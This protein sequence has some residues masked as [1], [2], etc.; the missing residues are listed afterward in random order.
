MPAV[1]P[2]SSRRETVARRAPPAGVL[3]I[4]AG[5]SLWGV[6]GVLRKPLTG[7]WSSWTIVLYEH[8]ILTV[9]VAPILWIHRDRVR[10]LS[11]AGWLSA[12]VIGWGGSAIATLLF[13]EAFA[14]AYANAD[15]VIL[16][17]K[18]QPLWAIGA[19]ALVVGERP[20]GELGVLLVPAAIGTYLLSFGWASPADAISGGELR[21]ALYALGAAAL[22][23]SATAFGRRGLRE[24][25]PHVLM[26]LRFALAL[27]FLAVIAAP[28]HALLPAH[29]ATAG[30]WLRLPLLAL[31]SGLI[32]ML[33]YYR[34][35]RSTPAP[36]ATIA[37]LAFPATALVVNYIWLDATINGM[38][39]AGFALLWATIALIHRVPV[40]VPRAAELVSPPPLTSGA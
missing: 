11:R 2:V 18:T 6:D 39:W 19:A 31:G 15:V 5:A 10:R 26:A 8:L 32:A 17:Q 7:E 37:E 28:K 22:W 29:A 14:I 27:P 24:L 3:M 36:I 1:D 40:A 34:G 21:P 30:D 33:L 12:I 9:A 35:L 23:G 16:L 13:T 20:R 4:A 25:E 38:Q